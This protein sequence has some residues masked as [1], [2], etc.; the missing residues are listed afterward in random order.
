MAQELGSRAPLAGI[1]NE[2]AAARTGASGWEI[3]NDLGYR[4]NPWGVHG[5]SGTIDHR[6]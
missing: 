5:F 4:V 3:I 6:Y 1:S 2:S